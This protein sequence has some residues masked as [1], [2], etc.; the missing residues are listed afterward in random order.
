[1][2]LRKFKILS[3]DCYGTLIDWETGI[4][5][6]L[7]PLM[8][9]AGISHDGA[10]AAYAEQ[11]SAQE[12]ETPALRYADI[13][14]RVHEDDMIRALCKEESDELVRERWSQEQYSLEIQRDC[15]PGGRLA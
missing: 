9:R 12:A 2:Q 3:F 4:L 1:M 13:L 14:T 6:A 5:A 7:A 8:A 11:E 15:F 10:L